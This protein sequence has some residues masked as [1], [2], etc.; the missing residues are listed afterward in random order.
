MIRGQKVT[1]RAVREEDMKVASRY[2]N[3][4]RSRG[5]FEQLDIMPEVL[6]RK[7]LATDGLWGDNEGILCVADPQDDALGHVR[8]GR[9]FT[10]PTRVCLEIS[11]AIYDPNNWGKGYMTEAVSIFVPYLFAIRGVERIQALVHP[12]NLGSIRVL[13]KCFFTFEGVL[14]KLYFSRGRQIDINIYSILRDECPQ[15][16]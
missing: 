9:P 8:Y 11:Y 12:E 3:D 5:P 4:V 16:E 7:Q 15:F 14:R 13:E 6:A 2:F 10:S 1:L